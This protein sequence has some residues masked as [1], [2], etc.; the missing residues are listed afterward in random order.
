MSFWSTGVKGRWQ[1]SS[2]VL[3]SAAA[4]VIA[5]AIVL[6]PGFQMTAIRGDPFGEIPGV[7]SPTYEIC[8]SGHISVHSIKVDG[9]LK[10]IARL[11]SAPTNLVSRRIAD[12]R[13]ATACP[14]GVMLGE[15]WNDLRAIEHSSQP[16]GANLQNV[17]FVR[18][19]DTG[20]VRLI[21]SYAGEPSPV[22][23]QAICQT[24][25][26]RGFPAAFP[27]DVAM[28]QTIRHTTCRDAGSGLS[29]S[30]RSTQ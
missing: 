30:S 23:I 4:L 6:R 11:I 19:A 14:P 28:G 16:A 21:V 24:L 2:K 18:A 12:W 29:D 5:I 13:G 25:D 20:T 15:A 17:M 27:I 10:F 7:G 3:L 22:S 1:R 9:F 8:F 26:W